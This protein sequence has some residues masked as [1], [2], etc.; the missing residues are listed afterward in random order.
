MDKKMLTMYNWA[1]FIPLHLIAISE[2]RY[3]GAVFGFEMTT[4]RNKNAISREKSASVF[5]R[6][7]VECS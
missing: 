7:S 5:Y 4:E 3:R 2:V 6:S 1:R